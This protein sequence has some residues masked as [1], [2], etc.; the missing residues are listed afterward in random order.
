MDKNR[1]FKTPQE[2][3]WAGEFGNEYIERNVGG[4]WVASNTALFAKIL[5]KCSRVSSL[6]EFGANIGLNLKAIRSL[7]PDAELEAIE[8]NATAVEQLKAWG[9]VNKVHHESILDFNAD[10][11]WDIALIKGVL[12]HINPD[13]LPNVYKALYNASSRYIIVAEYYNPSPVEVNYRGHT[14]KLF[15]RDFAGEMLDAYP[16]LHLVEYGFVWRRDPMYPQD[17]CTWFLLE[18]S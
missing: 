4:R 2:E 5:S 16:D 1:I 17:D 8:I 15:K 7:L 11:T 18:K 9:G 10:R 12:I 14:G 13:Q 6:I 3:F